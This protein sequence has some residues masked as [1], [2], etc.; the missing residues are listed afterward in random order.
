MK[1]NKKKIRVLVVDDSAFMRKKISEM[2]NSAADME[3]AASARNGEEALQSIVS[4]NPDVVTMDVVMGKM[5]GITCL[6]YIMSE[7][8]LPVI[9]L[10]AYTEYGGETTMKALE[11]GAVDFILK[12][13]A[14]ISLKIDEIQKE[15]LDKIRL[16]AQVDVQKLKTILPRKATPVIKRES[17]ALHKIIAIGAST[18]GPRALTSIIPKL[19][20]DFPAAVLVVQHMP[21][22]FTK[23]F[24]E[25]LNWE[26]Q[27]HVK[28]A[29][30]GEEIKAGVVYVGPGGCT[31]KVTRD[32][33]GDNRISIQKNTTSTLLSPSVDIL[34][35]SVAQY[36][37]R[38]SI[39]LVLTGMGSDGTEGMRAIY[40]ASGLTLAQDK[41]SSIVYGMP[42]ACVE[43]G[44]VQQVAALNDIPSL[45]ESVVK[46]DEKIKK[47]I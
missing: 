34:M 41:S 3:L 32:E 5:D 39:G 28:E 8:P 22:G 9:M 19:P 18:G 36:Y 1:K 40:K 42:R 35:K 26:S 11:L 33:K 37:G 47:A 10:S 25:R 44:V 30:D 23:S 2:I 20:V 21:K 4:L 14:E 27:L 24:A 46:R 29:E 13:G 31:F 38:S 16:A 7:C 17:P 45:L 6:G 43:A 12:P 15:L